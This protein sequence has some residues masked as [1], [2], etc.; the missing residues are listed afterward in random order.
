MWYGRV[1]GWVC[2]IVTSSLTRNSKAKGYEIGCE[3]GYYAGC[4]AAWLE[5]IKRWNERGATIIAE[6]EAAEVEA[7]P[8]AENVERCVFGCWWWCGLCVGV[9]WR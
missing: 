4:A 2:L 3:L 1:Y 5:A 6:G 9:A 8:P 7:A